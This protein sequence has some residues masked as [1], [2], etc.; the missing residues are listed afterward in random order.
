LHRSCFDEL[1]N[2]FVVRKGQH[3]LQDGAGLNALAMTG[4]F[5][6]F[7]FDDIFVAAWPLSFIRPGFALRCC[8]LILIH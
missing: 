4:L 2:Q 7:A 3:H 8:R 5:D 1:V 6:H